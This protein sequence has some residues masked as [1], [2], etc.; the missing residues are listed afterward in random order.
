[1]R[2]CTGSCGIQGADLIT[3]ILELVLV[4]AL[5]A[6]PPRVLFASS[7]GSTRVVALKL[8]SIT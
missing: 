2:R 6:A 5:A 8:P 7:L 4:L 1:M 3:K